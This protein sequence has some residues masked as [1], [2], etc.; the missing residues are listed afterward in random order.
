MKFPLQIVREVADV[1]ALG[2][3]AGLVRSFLICCLGLAPLAGVQ[4]S[5]P[6]EVSGASANREAPPVVV[7]RDAPLPGDDA[8]ADMLRT[9][10]ESAGDARSDA[11]SRLQ[12]ADQ[13]RSFYETHGSDPRAAEA[14][15]WEVLALID[16]VETGDR[17][18]AQRLQQAVAAMR[19]RQDLPK[20]ERARAISAYEF[21]S[22]L[23]A[24]QTLAER[25][26]ATEATAL[27]LM[28]E[29]PGE[30]QGSQA[31]LVVARA[32]DPHESARIAQVV[33]EADAPSAHREEAQR[34]V[35]RVDL[36]DRR[37]DEVLAGTPAVEAL[38]AL[39]DDQPIVVYSWASWGPGSHELGRMLQARRFAALGV[40]LDE[41]VEAAQVL[42]HAVNLGGRQIYD[43]RGR[44]G[45][46]AA[47][48]K[49]ST[50]G[51]IYLVDRTGVI[52]DVRGGHDLES[53]LAALG[54]ATPELV[55]P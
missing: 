17:S 12:M 11:I 5:D 43:E 35:E 10:R 6:G 1:M 28:Q 44:E 49:F 38:G 19:S 24:T 23:R 32:S 22:A 47:R 3:R 50:A 53:K 41:D 54:F 4:T 37:L 45:E 9:Q 7:E 33:V 2:L 8:W 36:L 31:L 18:S 25:L 46:V 26:A 20:A 39:P 15:V 16:A 21:R 27:D 52:R 55:K 40:C 42:H 30:P 48:L 51:Q 13:A 29:F 14:R 34:L